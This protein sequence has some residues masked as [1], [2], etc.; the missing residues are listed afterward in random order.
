MFIDSSSL[1]ADGQGKLYRLSFKL[2]KMKKK[3]KILIGVG[4]A[5]LLVAILTVTLV[6]VL[7]KEEWIVLERSFSSLNDQCTPD[8]SGNSDWR[9]KRCKMPL[10]CA[11]ARDQKTGKPLSKG[12]I[13]TN[14]M[15]ACMR[16]WMDTCIQVERIWEHVC[17][18][19]CMHACWGTLP[20][21]LFVASL[22]QALLQLR[23]RWVKL[24]VLCL[25]LV[26][27]VRMSGIIVW[28][29]FLLLCAVHA[30]NNSILCV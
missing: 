7:R 1:P 2:Y 8:W 6:I 4:V 26:F 3:V 23:D 10:I 14:C 22:Q 13:R 29:A 20:L 28:G 16:A 21:L 5:L 11:A 9:R 15:H 25:H 19:I 18:H 27:V 30:C 24:P 12:H 17:M